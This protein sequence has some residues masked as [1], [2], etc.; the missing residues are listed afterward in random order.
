MAFLLLEGLAA[1][2][3]SANLN[4]FIRNIFKNMKF[5]RK[6]FLLTTANNKQLTE[7]TG[8]QTFKNTACHG[9]APRYP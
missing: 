8:L 5:G 6:Y 7:G 3:S 4:L 2:G 1:R 9:I